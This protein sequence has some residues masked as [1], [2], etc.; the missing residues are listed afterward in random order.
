MPFGL[1][2]ACST[3]VRVVRAVL[4]PISGF[5]E[6]Y[7]DGIGVGSQDWSEHLGHIRQLLEIMSRVGMTLSL[8]KCG[9]L[10]PEVKF[11]GHF[12]GSGKRRLDPQR[13]EGFAEMER[14]RTKKELRKLLAA[15]GYYR[16][17][18][19]HFA[20]IA[21]PLTDLTGNNSPNVLP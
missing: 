4:Q 8:A 14:P 12:V 5:S 20:H 6:S 15:F 13:L 18:I 16:E 9:F 1:K 17:Y 10:K 11:V 3:F 2:N 21:K 7:V 19:P